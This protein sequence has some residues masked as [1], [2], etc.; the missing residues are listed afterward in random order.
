[1]SST[2]WTRCAGDSEL[3]P[4]RLEAWRAVEAQHQV[5][6]RRLVDSD[7]EQRVLEELIEGAKPPERTGGRLHYLLATPFRYPPLPHGSRFGRRTDS[8][9]WYGAESLRT[10]FAE[11]AY[12]RLVFLEGTRADLGLVETELTAF[13]AEVRTERGIDLTARPF[14]AHEAALASPMSYIETQALG[15]AMRGAGVEAFRYRSAR[16]V[17]GGVG[18]GALSPAAFG[19]RQPRGFENWRCTATRR[20]VE[21][22]SRGYF[23]RT[24]HA[25]ARAEFLV[26]GRLPA[27]AI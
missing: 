24:V 18:L 12:Y 4:L 2:I 9:I 15:E 10:V 7:A 23:G 19:R 3:R 21:V 8:G 27:P 13:R 22:A 17:Q 16:D 14:A 11:V 26:E 1:M 6:T 20:R 25:Y 5:S